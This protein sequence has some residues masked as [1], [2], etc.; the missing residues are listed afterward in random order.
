MRIHVETCA[1]HGGAPMPAR[2]RLGRARVRVVET[3]DQWYGPDYRYIKVKGDDRCLYILRFHDAH[4]N[5]ELT[6]YKSVRAQAMTWPRPVTRR[7]M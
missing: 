7:V 4:E 1:G 6:M 3:L 2:F 5:W